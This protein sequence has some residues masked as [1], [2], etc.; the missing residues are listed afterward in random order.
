[1]LVQRH[2]TPRRY[3]DWTYLETLWMLDDVNWMFNRLDWTYFMSFKHQ[4]FG[5]ATLEFLSS[6]NYTLGRRMWH[7]FG[8][9]NFRLFSQKYELNF[10]EVGELFHFH[11][12][13]KDM[14]HMT[15]HVA[16][17]FT[18]FW[19]RLTSKRVETWRVKIPPV[20]ITPQLDIYKIGYQFKLVCI[21][22]SESFGNYHPSKLSK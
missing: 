20:S 14:N 11:V 22:V 6:F 17:N 10:A 8:T 1:M 12:N 9:I 16:F 4:T 13:S 15:G 19:R 2:I 21:I 18:D 3:I 7:Q 5:C